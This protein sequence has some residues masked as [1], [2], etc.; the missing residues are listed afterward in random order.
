MRKTILIITA[1]VFVCSACT[2]FNKYEGYMRQAKDFMREENYEESLEFINNSLI[3]EPTSEDAIALKAMAE[4][5]LKKE[6]IE[7][8]KAKFVEMTT[9]IYERLLTLT[10]EI[11]EDASNLSIS[12]AEILRPQVEQLQAELSKMSKEWND[13][14]RYSKAF[15]YLNTA[16]DNLNLCITAIIENI[17]EPILVNEN[18]SKFDVIR[19]SLNSNDSKVRAR[20]SFQD[21]TSNLQ[22]FI[23]SFRTNDF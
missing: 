15:Q 22:S 14:E 3:E 13:S 16:A 10:K 6:K 8:E 23:Q 12:D 20:L 7:D 2:M 19:Q 11:N 18:S 21:F 5:A 4:E 1:M 9:P 17:S